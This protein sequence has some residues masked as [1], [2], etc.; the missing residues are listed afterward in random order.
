ME[1]TV[2]L[3]FSLG[4]GEI[5]IIFLFV[6]LFF[7]SKRIPEFARTLGKGMRQFRDATDEIQRDIQKGVN[8]VRDDVRKNMEDVKDVKDDIDKTIK[9]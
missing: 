5:F 6:L 8:N 4:G 2:F 1:L 3:F 9:E 7:G